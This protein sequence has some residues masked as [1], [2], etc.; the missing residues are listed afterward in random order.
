MKVDQQRD[1]AM[2]GRANARII[3]V[4]GLQIHPVERGMYDVFSGDGFDTH[5]R[6]R[7]YKGVWHHMRGER[8]DKALL[9]VF[10]RQ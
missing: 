1:A 7:N 8:L 6:Y 5:S 10:G 3:K 2:A 9:P 4:N